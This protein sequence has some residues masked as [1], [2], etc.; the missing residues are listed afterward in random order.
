[1][2]IIRTIDY[3]LVFQIEIYFYLNL[4]FETESKW[5]KFGHRVPLRTL[6]I[7]NILRNLHAAPLN[8][9][10]YSIIPNNMVNFF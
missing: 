5:T 9:I 6:V 3:D 7:T 4:L 1:M 10:F 2:R 8:N